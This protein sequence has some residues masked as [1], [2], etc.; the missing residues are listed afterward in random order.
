MKN[1]DKG[2]KPLLPKD[3]VLDSDLDT[4]ESVKEQDGI[5]EVTIKTTR[6]SGS[7][8]TNANESTHIKLLCEWSSSGNSSAN[9]SNVSATVSVYANMA[10]TCRSGSHVTING[11]K[12]DYNGFVVVKDGKKV[13]K[14]IMCNHTVNNIAHNADGSK[15]ITISYGWGWHG[16]VWHNSYSGNIS[17]VSGSGTAVLDQ[18]AKIPTVPNV[19]HAGGN[20][21]TNHNGQRAYTGDQD[22]TIT[23]SGGNN[24]THR[25]VVMERYDG[26]WKDY[27][28]PGMNAWVNGNVSVR[29]HANN[30]YRGYH[31]RVRSRAKSSTNHESAFSGWEYFYVNDLTRPGNFR[32]STNRTNGKVTISW[33]VAT[34]NIYAANSKRNFQIGTSV[35]GVFTS[36]H[37]KQIT[38]AQNQSDRSM[39]IDISPYCSV[40]SSVNLYMRAS[41][42]VE[43]GPV[44]SGHASIKR[45]SPPTLV[46][47]YSTNI[48]NDS[49][50]GDCFENSLSF[51]WPAIADVDGT[52]SSGY[53]IM[54]KERINGTWGG[55]HTVVSKHTHREWNAPISHMADADAVQF[56]AQAIDDLGTPGG[57]IYARW[58]YKNRIGD[59]VTGVKFAG[60]NSGNTIEAISNFS[61][62]RG[63]A[64]NGNHYAKYKWRVVTVNSSG[65]ESNVQTGETSSL[66]TSIDFSKVPRGSKF[67]FK[68]KGVC[69]IGRDGREGESTLLTKNSLPYFI[70]NSV[71]SS[72]R[73]SAEFDGVFDDYINFAFPVIQD[74]D[75]TANSQYRIE[76][77]VN[78]GTWTHIENRTST[79]FNHGFGQYVP[80]GA[81]LRIQISPIDNLG[82]VGSSKVSEAYT[83]TGVP[84][85]PSVIN[86]NSSKFRNNHYETLDSVTWSGASSGTGVIT[87]YKCT[88]IALDGNGNT[89]ES[90][91]YKTTESI[92]RPALSLI[93][94]TQHFRV[95]VISKDAFG[96]WSEP[97]STRECSRNNVP[98][99]VNGFKTEGS[100][101]NFYGTVPLTWDV[102]SDTDGDSISYEIH[103]R[104]NTGSWSIIAASVRS[105]EY[106]HSIEG[107]APNTKLGYKIIAVDQLDAKGQESSIANSDSI[108]VNTPPVACVTK[109]PFD[110]P[111][112][113]KRPRL[114]IEK[115]ESSGGDKS[116]TLEITINN[117]TYTSSTNPEL[118]NKRT[119]LGRDSASF[120]PPMTLTPGSH[121]VRIRTFDGMQYSP[122]TQETVEIK[123]MLESKKTPRVDYIT[124]DSINKCCEMI[125]ANR[126]AYKKS[127]PLK[128]VNQGHLITASNLNSIYKDIHDLSKSITIEYP[129]L[130]DNHPLIVLTRTQIIDTVFFNKMIDI[131][132][133]P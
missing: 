124:A 29:F 45:N 25:Y 69:T 80:R 41:E 40:G 72:D 11:N 36:R 1:K 133:K 5:T 86:L 38:T 60:E 55:W 78:N 52:G 32:A 89:L 64:Y 112:Y 47:S 94:R 21:F 49:I 24:V 75:T 127:E 105:N 2:T 96:N 111:V 81:E 92:A 34:S 68:V 58:L 98:T 43:W 6:T 62:N 122:A 93:N 48:D 109:A 131:I 3:I 130:N 121:I 63:T 120:I 56:Y 39:E 88:L 53:K 115:L 117:N 102:A 119:Y 22:I 15:S 12:K 8:S 101:L 87:E 118:F 82:A 110:S 57:D 44:T 85:P 128:Q 99:K 4:I 90:Y 17:T 77:S 54:K 27:N 126:K 125:N 95:E 67:K 13:I 61:W 51:T 26:G 116:L 100:G 91:E 108:S 114:L 18:L 73:D 28:R 71:I 37:F 20:Y 35:N 59:A 84:E 9:S 46:G 123:Q 83:R 113:A 19:G 132:E 23:S 30:G 50:Y 70:A 14:N 79:S 97:I 65:V 31:F 103:H 129:G 42:E 107:Y 33:D 104:R 76:Y 66:N 106:S 10:G 16:Y 74:A 7:F